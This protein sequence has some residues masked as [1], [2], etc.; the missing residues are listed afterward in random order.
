MKKIK[1]IKIRGANWS[2]AWFKDKENRIEYDGMCYI[3]EKKIE[4]R[5]GMSDQKTLTVF[6][7]EVF[8]AFFWDIDEEVIK[9]T[10][11]DLSLI[12]K[13]LQSR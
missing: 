4:I 6:I 11:E 3:K 1:K 12:I 9:E 7:H 13:R 10:S 2:V 5:D 8:H